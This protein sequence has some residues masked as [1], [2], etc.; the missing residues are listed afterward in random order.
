MEN[1]PE[2]FMRVLG[3]IVGV[4]L[5]LPGACS[6]GFMAMSIGQSAG[7][8]GPIPLLWFVCFLISAGGVAMIV[9]SV[10]GPRPP[11]REP[12]D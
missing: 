3:F 4:I 8:L 10:R 5:L 6:L 12:P 7:S 1:A 11:P 2:A 9:K